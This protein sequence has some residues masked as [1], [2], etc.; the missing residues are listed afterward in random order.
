MKPNAL[1]LTKIQPLWLLAGLFFWLGCGSP[2][3][4]TFTTS[5]PERSIVEL[6]GDIFLATVIWDAGSTSETTIPSGFLG[7]NFFSIPPGASAGNHDF[8]LERNG[9]RSP[10]YSFNV[11]APVPFTA[12]RIDYI[13]LAGTSFKP[14]GLVNTL[15]VVQGANIDVGAEVIVDGAVMPSLPY[16]VLINDLLGIDPNTLGFPI[17]H[18]TAIVVPTGDLS[19]GSLL[20]IQLRNLDSQLSNTVGYRLPSS[21]ASLDSDGDNIPD[22]WE[23]AGYDADGDGTI[24]VDLPAL[25]ADPMRRDI[26]MEVD[27]MNS[28]TNPP[29]AAVFTAIE[30]A[31]DAAPIINAGDIPNGVNLVIDRSGSVPFSTLVDMEDPTNAV[32]DLTNFYDLKATNFD[33]DNRGRLYH[34][35]IWA[36]M[37]PGGYSGISD[38]SINAAGTDFEDPGDDLIV[39]FD[40][41]PT[42]YQT[43]RSGAETLMHE[44]GHNMLQRHGGAN[45]YAYNPAYNSIM[46]YSW[47]LRTGHYNST[48]RGAPICYPL[49]YGQTGALETNGVVF[50]PMGM[51]IDYSDGMGR[52][53]VEN[54]F[55]E[56]MGICG[57]IALDWNSDGDAVDAVASQDYNGNGVFD[58]YSDFCNWCALDYRGPE[59]DG[60]H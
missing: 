25:G 7:G 26:F 14:G 4:T 17:Y 39:S 23:T 41:F 6:T 5:G 9:S 46:S 59:L 8:Q 50:T 29:A 51:V 18:Y 19:T 47:Q 16:K 40:D 1:F 43:D 58:T 24:D 22:E 56:P 36:N 12:P 20:N 33:D 38:P 57:N 27:I 10:V 32:T 28:L 2:T 60:A 42:S 11:T 54:N 48:R 37:I 34:Y 3:A 13:T 44:L 53:V 49:Y 52:D 35:V 15:L 55:N 30:D 31:F 45:H 21:E